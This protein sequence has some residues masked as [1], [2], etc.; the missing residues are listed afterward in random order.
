MSRYFLF[1]WFIIIPAL[2]LQ[3]QGEPHTTSGK[4]LKHYNLGKQY[5]DFLDY[6]KAVVELKEAVKIDDG[7]IEAH[8]MLAEVC[9]DLRDYPVAINSF[10][11][12]VAIDPEFFPN[13]LYNLAHIEHLSGMYNDAKD[14]YQA[15]LNQ[16]QGSEK[17]VRLAVKGVKN[18]EFALQALLNPVP[19]NPVNLGKNVN[20][21][22]DEYWPSLTADEKTLIF[23]VLVKGKKRPDLLGISRNEDF[24]V[25]KY[26]DGLWAKREN[27]GPPLNTSQNE[28]A[29]SLSVDGKYMFFTAC[30][31]KEGYGS[32]DIYFSAKF[33]NRWSV[34]S[35]IGAP[36]NSSS[37]EAQ[38]CL[39][40]DGNTL[41]FISN[42]PGGKGKMDIWKSSWNDK[43][44]WNKPVNLGDTINTSDD[45]MSPYIHP[46]NQT[47]FFS[48]DGH[49]GMGGFDL[50]RVKKHDDGTWDQPE[51]LGY[52]IN[53]HGDEI[54]LIVNAK[55]DKAYFSSDRLSESGKDIY[56]F[57]LY[58]EVRPQ[59]VSYMTG[60]V[61]DIGTGKPL[62][63]K[64]ELIDIKS[65]NV[66]MEAFSGK[67]GSFLV[68]I[69]TN[70]DYALNVSKEGFLFFSEHFSLSGIHEAVNPY[71]RD[72]PL[73]PII[74]GQKSVLRN[75][76]FEYNSFRLRDK[77]RVELNKLVEF[78]SLN[79]GVIMEIGGHTDNIGDKAYNITLSENRAKAVYKYLIEHQIDK[80]RLSFK[81]YGMSQPVDD[82]STP[83]GRARNRRTEMKVIGKN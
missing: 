4:A 80:K 63:A 43:G 1:V 19:Y 83:E 39:S 78:L 82:N 31:R 56:E 27:L 60:K 81:G 10:K 24:Y 34:A 3:G 5:Y 62:T 71:H 66:V 14:H 61:F 20:S 73:S 16:G 28:G 33:Q 59:P 52:P 9:V 50:F 22:Y 42:C 64:F 2:V 36:V 30:N 7:F 26:E 74:T 65:A 70:K 29:Q 72:V 48:S 23:T 37:W 17:R 40:A 41:Y 67:D 13:A 69:P 11:R 35:N 45:E 55:G 75:V 25:S 15:F 8:L 6:V 53:T 46:D 76:F 58:K 32:C 54:G 38:P 77:S 47:L 57:E 79:S 44:Y 12:A 49:P 51:N 68:C 18:C 21:E